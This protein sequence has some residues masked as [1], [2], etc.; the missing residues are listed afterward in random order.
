MI[1]RQ[2]RRISPIRRSNS[3]ATV[4]GEA[5]PGKLIGLIVAEKWPTMCVHRNV[6]LRRVRNYLL[7]ACNEPATRNRV[8]ADNCKSCE[9]EL[10][11][12]GALSTERCRICLEHRSTISFFFE[13]ARFNSYTMLNN[14]YRS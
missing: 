14:P 11:F 5:T 2:P 9:S 1:D 10:Q 3:R 8:S 12:V 4:D 13:T 6:L 7:V